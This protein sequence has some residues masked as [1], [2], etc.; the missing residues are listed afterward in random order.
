MF[1]TRRT[2]D[3]IFFSIVSL[4]YWD[5]LLCFIGLAKIESD[6]HRDVKKKKEKHSRCLSTNAK[7]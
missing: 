6:K 5:C 2:N 3:S 4:L 1:D 7:A